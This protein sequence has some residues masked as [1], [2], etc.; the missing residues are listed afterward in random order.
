MHVQN[1]DT[2]CFLSDSVMTSEIL[3]PPDCLPVSAEQPLKELITGLKVSIRVCHFMFR[4]FYIETKLTSFSM[5][6][7]LEKGTSDVSVHFINLML[8]RKIL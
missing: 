1:I 3:Y 8:H 6:I 5:E 4:S 7:S 2:F